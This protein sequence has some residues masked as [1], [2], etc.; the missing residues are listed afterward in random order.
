MFFRQG[1]PEKVTTDWSLTKG[2]RKRR[3]FWENHSGRRTSDY[4]GPQAEKSFDSLRNNT[5]ASVDGGNGEWECFRRVREGACFWPWCLG[6][7][8]VEWAG[9]RWGTNKPGGRHKVFPNVSGIFT[10]FWEDDWTL[11]SRFNSH[12]SEFKPMMWLMALGRMWWVPRSIRRFW[13]LSLDCYDKMPQTG[14]LIN[15]KNFS[16]FWKLEIREKQAQSFERALGV[17]GFSLYPH[18]GKGL[19]NAMASLIMLISFMRA[20]MT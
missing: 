16:Q 9:E 2:R 8:T 3:T 13:W 15:H 14:W 6:V 4:K 5:K 20:L 19:G 12:A 17:T 10:L 1:R 7:R 11:V 18:M